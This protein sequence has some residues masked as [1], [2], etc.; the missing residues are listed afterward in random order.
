MN[1]SPLLIFDGE[2]AFCNANV[3][4]ILRNE[5][6]E[7]IRFLWLQSP[8]TAQ[9]LEQNNIPEETDSIVFI[10]DGSVHLRSSAALSICKYLRWPWNWLRIFQVLPSSLRDMIYDF[11]ARHRKRIMG[12]TSCVLPIGYEHRFIEAD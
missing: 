12:S 2:C 11:I 8:R 7:S 1:G 6:G 10:E 5:R 4:F 3:D 9:I